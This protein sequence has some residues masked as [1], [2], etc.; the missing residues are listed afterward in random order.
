VSKE[1]NKFFIKT[2]TKNLIYINGAAL[3]GA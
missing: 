3:R 1:T 2:S